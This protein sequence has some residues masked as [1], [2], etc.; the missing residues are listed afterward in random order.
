MG[1]NGLSA[2]SGEAGSSEFCWV[3]AVSQSLAL[4]HPFRVL[5]PN[6]KRS[7]SPSTPSPSPRHTVN[8][9]EQA[10]ADDE[11]YAVQA[12]GFVTLARSNVPPRP[13]RA[14]LP[15]PSPLNAA[16]CSLGPSVSAPSASAPQ[17]PHLRNSHVHTNSVSYPPRARIAT[18]DAH[19]RPRS[20]STSTSSSSAYSTSSTT[21]Q[22][23]PS[24]V[25]LPSSYTPQAPGAASSSRSRSPSISRLR[26]GLVPNFSRPTSLAL[27]LLIP[28]SATAT[29]PVSHQSACFAPWEL[30]RDYTVEYDPVSGYASGLDACRHQGKPPPIF[31]DIFTENT[32]L[33][34]IF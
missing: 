15:P 31:C 11:F 18:S 1:M 6:F 30:E 16:P 17:S 14:P 8:S 22:A 10:A 2:N 13:R 27:G 5:E 23:A 19:A 29:V 12:H 3:A 21:S 7:S 26:T 34:P 20:S 9:E 33:P 24:S 4:A 32:L 25:W 28:P